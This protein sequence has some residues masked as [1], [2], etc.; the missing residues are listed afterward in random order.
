MNKSYDK[1][2]LKKDPSTGYVMVEDGE[3]VLGEVAKTDC[4]LEPRHVK[5]LN[6]GWKM[7]GVLFVEVKPAVKAEPIIKSDARLALEA[8]AKELG[9]KFN[10]KIGDVKLKEKIETEKNK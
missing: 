8:E 5:V 3:P 1:Y 9:I 2:Y 7:S 10:P 6:K 4:R